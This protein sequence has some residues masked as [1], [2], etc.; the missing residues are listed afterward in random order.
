[1]WQK[2]FHVVENEI[3]PFQASVPGIILSTGRTLYVLSSYGCSICGITS[4]SYGMT[5]GFVWSGFFFAR[6]GVIAI[7]VLMFSL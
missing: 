5:W 3:V 1:M 4:V 7:F 6:P 2:F